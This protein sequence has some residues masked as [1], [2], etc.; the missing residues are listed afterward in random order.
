MSTA[1]SKVL[2]DGTQP[3]P[4]VYVLSMAAFVLQRQSGVAVLEIVRSA[5]SE[6]VHEWPFIEASLTPERDQGYRIK[7]PAL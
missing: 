7:P 6:L 5:K 1:I 4:F 2:L 3:Y